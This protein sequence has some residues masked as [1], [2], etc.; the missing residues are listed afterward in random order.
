MKNLHEA[1]LT[2]RQRWVDKSIWAIAVVGLALVV[3][4]LGQQN[5][6]HPDR[7][8]ILFNTDL[9]LLLLDGAVKTLWVAVV[10][11]AISL[12]VAVIIARAN[13]SRFRWVRYCTIGYVEVFRGLP[14]LLLIF[15]LYLGLPALGVPISTFWALCVGIALF[16]SA[17]LAEILRGG[18]DSLGFGQ[19]EA[20]ESLGMSENSVFIRVLLPQATRNMLPA[21]IAQLVILVKE[22]SLG[23]IIGYTELLRNGRTAVEYLGSGFAPAVYL[24]V[25]VIFI[26]IN[27]GLTILARR[28]GR[29]KQ[30]PKV[31]RT[32][33]TATEPGSSLSAAEPN[34]HTPLDEAKSSTR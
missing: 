22:T 25:A 28:V 24:L 1:P 20:A 26:A 13:Y 15:F 17:N 11:L 3:I 9:L 10:S 2:D 27:L 7:W 33:P 34:I 14:L 30:L 5:F 4:L 32:S 21:G 31:Q 23:F 16:T 29:E 19:R 8:L 18:V 12:V 6:W